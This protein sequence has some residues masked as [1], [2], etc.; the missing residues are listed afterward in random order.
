M[1]KKAAIR[2]GNLGRVVRGG[3][4]VIFKLALR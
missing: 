3:A 4:K 2:K 1:V